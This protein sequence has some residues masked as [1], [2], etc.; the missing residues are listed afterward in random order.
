M[1]K[2]EYADNQ[3]SD[4]EILIAI[5]S[6]VVGV[7]VLSM[8]RTLADQTNGADGLIPL[9]IGGAIVV[10]LTWLVAKL[11]AKFPQESFISYASFITSK[12]VGTVL[13]LLLSIQG[14]L[15]AAYETRV[16]AAVAEQYLFSRTPFGVV[17]LTFLLI[18]IYAVAGSRAGLFRLNMMFFPFIVFISLLL[19]LFTTGLFEP[20]NMLPVLTTGYSGQWDAFKQSAFS[21]MGF[22]FLLFYTSLVKSPA[23]VPKK[24]AAGMVT[25][26]LLY[27]MIYIMCIGVFGNLAAGNLQYPTVELAKDVEIP[28][29][30][31][32]RFES[33]FFVI[34]IMAIFNTCIMALDS[35]VFALNSMFKKNRKMQLIFTLSP[36]VYI[37]GM[38]PQ[39]V[40]EIAVFGTIVSVYG[41]AITISVTV[42]LFIVLKV[43]GGKRND[44]S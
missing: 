8:P 41:Y 16:I 19:V 24:A 30:F 20:G 1:K 33:L 36:L 31:F 5:P 27:I 32:E 11:A 39:N 17:G 2:F 44:P 43:R 22:G 3:I 40:N 38:L 4:K 28:G 34:W 14:L 15:I 9:A 35:A 26:V 18:V 25:A 6:I 42:L 23:N 10:F 21:F 7:G 29:G 12:P 37:V 13:T